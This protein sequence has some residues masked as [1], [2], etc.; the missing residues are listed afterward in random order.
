MAAAVV[1]SAAALRA[2]HEVAAAA[3]ARVADLEGEQEA[4]QVL[5]YF[6]FV[7]ALVLLI[8]FSFSLSFFLF[9]SLF[10]SLNQN[11]EGSGCG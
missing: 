7:V 5:I 10:A 2:S 4:A 3:E 8:L 9:E 1:V 6:R 11:F